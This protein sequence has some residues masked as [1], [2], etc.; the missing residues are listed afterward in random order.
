MLTLNFMSGDRIQTFLDQQELK[1]MS[2]QSVSDLSSE[3]ERIVD[4]HGNL[5]FKRAHIGK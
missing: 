3:I 4:A 5:W 1:K 2:L